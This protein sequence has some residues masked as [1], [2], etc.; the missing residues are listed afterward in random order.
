MFMAVDLNTA[1]LIRGTCPDGYHVR[2]FSSKNMSKGEALVG[3]NLGDRACIFRKK[4]GYWIADLMNADPHNEA[5]VKLTM[6]VND[7]EKNFW[8]KPAEFHSKA[9]SALKL[10]KSGLSANATDLAT[11]KQHYMKAAKVI[12]AEQQAAQAVGHKN[13]GAQVNEPT[14]EEQ[15]QAVLD[16]ATKTGA[17]ALAKVGTLCNQTG[18]TVMLVSAVTIASWAALYF[19]WP[20]Q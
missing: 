18:A 11:V 20:T 3:L 9:A 15:I 16:Y 19:L 14:A 13:G 12:L 2:L 5:F 4:N 8:V 17:D 6:R 1:T 10:A 7:A